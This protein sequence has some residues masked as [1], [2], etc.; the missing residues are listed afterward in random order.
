MNATKAR[1]RRSKPAPIPQKGVLVRKPAI[2]DTC[3]KNCTVGGN[4][5]NKV[6]PGYYTYYDKKLCKVCIKGII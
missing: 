5:S 6:S 2:C 1:G 3:E 4:M